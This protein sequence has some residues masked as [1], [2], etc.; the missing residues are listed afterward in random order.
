VVYSSSESVRRLGRG[1]SSVVRETR[2]GC[3]IVNYSH[4]RRSACR[5]ERGR[6]PEE[7]SENDLLDV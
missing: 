4:V 1:V 5:R 7:G 3:T 6:I 2:N